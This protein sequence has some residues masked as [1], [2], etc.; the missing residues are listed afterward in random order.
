LKLLLTEDM[1]VSEVKDV[2]MC[3][4]R[5]FR[6]AVPTNFWMVK[7]V[8]VVVVGVVCCI[9]MGSCI[10][11]DRCDQLLDESL[12][13]YKAAMAVNFKAPCVMCSYI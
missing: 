4:K 7:V 10:R 9:R 2:Q 5:Q 8:V 12:V 6:C 11:Q 3:E 1:F 13:R